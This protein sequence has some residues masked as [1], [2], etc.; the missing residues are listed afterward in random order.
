MASGGRASRPQPLV[1][2]TQTSGIDEH[3]DLATVLDTHGMKW[4]GPNVDAGAGNG[5]L[6][7]V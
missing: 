2:S 7:I 5:Q 1:T 4:I 3:P 6:T